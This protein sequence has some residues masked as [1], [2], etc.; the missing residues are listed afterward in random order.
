MILNSLPPE[1]LD[2][3]CE[4][5]ETGKDLKVFRL[6][7]KRINNVASR[8]LWNTRALVID[9][10]L[11]KLRSGMEMLEDLK[12]RCKTS[13]SVRALKIIRLDPRTIE[14]S[15]TTSE[16]EMVK[17][18]RERLVEVLPQALSALRN[19]LYA[20]WKISSDD[21]A[22]PLNKGEMWR[23]IVIEPLSQLTELN[24]LIL[25]SDAPLGLN[26][27][28]LGGFTH[29]EHLTIKG[30][31]NIDA[32]TLETNLAPLLSNNQKL[33]SL[34]LS[35]GYGSPD[36]RLLFPEA[37]NEDSGPQLEHLHLDNW[38]FTVN[39]TIISRLRNLQSLK[40]PYG[41]PTG[42]YGTIWTAFQE[43]GI[44]LAEI[45]LHD[46]NTGFLDY[47]ESFT[48]LEFLVLRCPSFRT[49]ANLASRLY[50][51]SLL[52]HRQTLHTM[53]IGRYSDHLAIGLER[54]GT[55]TGFENLF[56]LSVPLLAN[57]VR[58]GE[59]KERDVVT[60]LIINLIQLPY[61]E[62]IKLDGPV[63]RE[64]APL[65]NREHLIS[66]ERMRRRVVESIERF[67]L[68]E[69]QLLDP[70]WVPPFLVSTLT[71]NGHYLDERKGEDGILAF[72][73]EKTHDGNDSF[74]YFNLE[75]PN[76][77]PESE[78]DEPMDW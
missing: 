21:L 25:S 71:P 73:R 17:R 2:E 54:A 4:T 29:L 38:R 43:E 28:S 45:T 52:K 48:G 50:Q 69:Q 55:F 74:V 14:K 56:S 27:M 64:P 75:N 31:W 33:Y 46:I 41:R 10:N 58:P 53:E 11:Q 39:P 37:E 7:N 19:L 8:H 77:H 13:E 72:V 20:Y 5:I 78:S 76:D 63:E 3:L 61:L 47:L 22:S 15:F 42:E 12:N 1:L 24:T 40:L 59:G 68:P 66:M 26:L 70:E 57:D 65:R 49:D 16:R 6:V 51:T 35:L 34:R 62:Y 44:H 67:R 9:L 32:K 30:R 60:A 18:G 36:F 23:Q